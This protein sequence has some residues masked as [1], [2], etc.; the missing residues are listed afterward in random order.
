[1]RDCNE[2][3]IKDRIERFN[4]NLEREKISVSV[5]YA[6]TDEIGEGRFKRLMALA[7]KRMYAEKRNVHKREEMLDSNE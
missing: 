5:G 2:D 6:Y 4:R 1:M 7:D 3:D